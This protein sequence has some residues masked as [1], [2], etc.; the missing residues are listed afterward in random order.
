MLAEL[1]AIGFATTMFRARAPRFGILGD[2]ALVF[3]A[4][5]Q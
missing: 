2:N 3:V 5:K 1:Q 4:R